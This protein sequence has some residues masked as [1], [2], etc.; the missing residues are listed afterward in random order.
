MQERISKKVNSVTIRKFEEKDIPNKVKWINDCA[1]NQYLHYNLP[2]TEEGTKAWFLKIKD[3]IDRYDS[4][5]EYNGTAVGIVGLLNI[6]HGKAEYYI[7][8]GET[9]YKGKGIAKKATL[10]LLDYA[11]VELNLSE[12]YLYTEV[13]NIPAQKLFEK[14]GFIQGKIFRNSAV[15][16]GKSVDRYYYSISSSNWRKP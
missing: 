8:M 1:N 11:F 16:R 6:Q 7:T 2:L 14:C 3:L 9:L 5:I 15:N 10:L 13:D 4:V 12:V